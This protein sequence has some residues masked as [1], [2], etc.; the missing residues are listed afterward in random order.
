[1]TLSARLRRLGLVLTTALPLLST[2]GGSPAAPTTTPV[3]VPTPPPV[4]LVA[5]A[6]A[7]TGQPLAGATVTSQGS[8]AFTDASGQAPLPA[9]SALGSPLDVSAAGFLDRKTTVQAATH[10]LWPKTLSSGANEAYTAH[11]AY[12]S[13]ADGA[14]EGAAPLRRV[15]PGFSTV[16]VYMPPEIRSDAFEKAATEAIG[17]INQATQG[18]P[19]YRL[20]FEKPAGTQVI[21]E[22][23]ID[24]TPSTCGAAIAYFV[25]S[26]VSSANPNELYAGNINFCDVKWTRDVSVIAHELGH[27][28]GLYHSN[29]RV[30]LMNPVAVGHQMFTG[31]EQLVVFLAKQRRGGNRYPDT[32][33]ERVTASAAAVRADTLIVCGR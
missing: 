22:F 9:T 26:L 15:V 28:L 7:S 32:D 29:R 13:T 33:R 2:C 23:S 31:E 14:V 19:Q 6:S 8:S 27:S 21:F 3:I 25:T 17:W 1:M 5:I 20:V 30:D 24:G 16:S 11:L 10:F 12:T 18:T 4:R